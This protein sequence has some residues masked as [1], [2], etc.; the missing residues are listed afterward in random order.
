MMAML[1]LSSV[2]TVM[3][4]EGYTPIIEKENLYE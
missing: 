2:L 3:V 1:S 4:P